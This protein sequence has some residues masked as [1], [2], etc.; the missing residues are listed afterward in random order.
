MEQCRIGDNV[1]RQQRVDEIVVEVEPTLIHGAGTGRKDT[2]PTDAEAIGLE[3]E[4]LHQGNIVT[5]AI[6]VVARNV[7]GVAVDR[8]AGTV[9][10][11]LPDAR[12][13]AI[14]ERAAFDLVR[15]RGSAPEERIG[16]A[17]RVAH[18]IRKS[19]ASS[20]LAKRNTE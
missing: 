4:S 12:A 17:V 1:L 13:C 15:R 9:R 8:A 11:A 10:K 6:V 20:M 14:G 16:K 18:A 3:A 19:I 2:T 7:T 5:P